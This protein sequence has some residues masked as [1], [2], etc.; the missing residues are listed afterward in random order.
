METIDL[1]E[2]VRTSTREVFTMMLGMEAV[3]APTYEERPAV[4]SFDG[5]ISIVGIAGSWMGVGSVYCKA[6][7]AIKISGTLLGIEP[8]TVTD[9]VLDAMAEVGNMIIGNVKTT[10]E[11]KLSVPLQL[12]IP[13]VVYG[14]NY[15][16]LNGLGKQR[17]VV[18]F[19]VEGNDLFVKV[20][21]APY[22][23]TTLGR[24]GGILHALI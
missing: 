1:A 16:A 15:K 7:L 10:L 18:P 5:V 12:S 8:A 4:E 19:Q 22:D 11:N 3:P 20:S 13:T 17:I 2:Y 21:L 24:A 14:R 23:D 9:E 6:D